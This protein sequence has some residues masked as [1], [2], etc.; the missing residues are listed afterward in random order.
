M[1]LTSRF[2]DALMFA[3]DRHADHV[4]KGTKI[5]YVAHLLG[6]ASLALEYG[7]NEEEAIAALLHDAVE[8]QKATLQEIR[9][10]FGD[11]LAD[12]VDGC[13]DTD[14][15]PKPPWRERKEA[16]IAHLRD[17][18]P[19]V[20]LVSAA[21]KLHNARAILRDYRN[22]REALWKRFN[23]GRDGTLWYYRELE[24]V[25]RTVR[26]PLADEMSVAEFL[27]TSVGV[28]LVPGRGAHS[29]C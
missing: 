15:T 18:S 6:V 26:S 8:D 7:A 25:F 2:N 9:E 11:A 1:K 4:R 17:A 12:I 10:H 13:S 23:G 28:A 5:P 29:W 3:M 20:R 21:D 16:Y 22:K 19:S 24:G 27:R 14:V